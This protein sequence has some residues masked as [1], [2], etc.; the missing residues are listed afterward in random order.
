MYVLIAL[1]FLKISVIYLFINIY[2]CTILSSL[3]QDS[4][5]FLEVLETLT[6][7]ILSNFVLFQENI[8]S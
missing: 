8:Y 2:L 4:S 3:T 1:F 5:V 6:F 7:I